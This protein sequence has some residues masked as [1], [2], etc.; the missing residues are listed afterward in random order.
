MD[1]V[2]ACSTTQCLLRCA[3]CCEH[4][5]CPHVNKL[6]PRHAGVFRNMSRNWWNDKACIASLIHCW[7]WCRLCIHQH[8]CAVD[9]VTGL[10]FRSDTLL[11]GIWFPQT[12]PHLRS[13]FLVVLVVPHVFYVILLARL[14]RRDHINTC[15]QLLGVLGDAPSPRTSAVICDTPWHAN[16]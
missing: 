1:L 4:I 12:S 9:K 8:I 6:T 5:A 10:A 2:S 16:T 15:L 3:C 13:V 7:R 14:P 11:E